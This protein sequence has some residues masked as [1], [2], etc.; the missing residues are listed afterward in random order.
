M[1]KTA[2][3]Q[4]DERAAKG[5]T[6]APEGQVQDKSYTTS[7]QREPIPVQADDE[8]V[9][10]PIDERKADSDSQLGT[11]TSTGCLDISSLRQT[12]IYPRY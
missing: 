11:L 1:S 12:R 10:D 8:P 6:D 4:T 3:V 7:T 5:D 9:E 2:W